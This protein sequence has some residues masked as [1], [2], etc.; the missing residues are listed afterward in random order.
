MSYAIP[1][2]TLLVRGR[3]I[4]T[5]FQ[6]FQGNDSPWRFGRIRGLIINSVAVLYVFIT[7]FVSFLDP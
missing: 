3:G 7:S 6:N 5:Q 2:L 4:L 1:V